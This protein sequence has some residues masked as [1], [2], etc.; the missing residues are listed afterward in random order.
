MPSLSFTEG[1]DSQAVAIVK[2]GADDGQVLYLHTEDCNGRKPKA[3]FNKTKY[4]K[5]FPKMKQAERTRA[6]IKIDEALTDNKPASFFDSEPQ[7][8]EVYEKVLADCKTNKE[9]IL[10]DDGIFELLPSPDP[11]K[12][13]VWFIAG[14]SGSGKS[15]KAK[16][17]L[18]YY[19]KLYPSRGCYLISKL[20]ED[21]TLDVLKFLK[22]VNIQSLV[23]DYPELSE[24]HECFVVFDD[25]DS[26]TG[27]EQKTVL[28]LIDDLASMGRHQV[29]SIA[30]LSH[31]HYCLPNV[32]VVSR[33]EIPTQELRWY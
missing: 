27:I 4:L 17:L 3:T 29:C 14:C 16:E 31:K 20:K 6:F 23:D 5:A 10:D 2:G 33:F 8:K 30:F 13:Q 19:H 7:I 32:N 22:R 28:K 9:I 21:S 11:K 18:T 24:F 12:R 26:L 15:Y 1:T 25:V